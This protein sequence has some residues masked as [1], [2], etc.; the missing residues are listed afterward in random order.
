MFKKKKKYPQN[1]EINQDVNNQDIEPNIC[2][3][4]GPDYYE[5]NL[6]KQNEIVFI[7][8]GPR[9]S[10]SDDEIQKGKNKKK[11]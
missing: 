3:Y 2:I 9:P 7:Y 4:A 11:C 10:L 6:P 5:N 8:G 1:H